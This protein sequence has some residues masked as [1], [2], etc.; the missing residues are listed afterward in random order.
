[1]KLGRS[2]RISKV[3]PHNPGKVERQQ[4]SAVTVGI[5]N[6]FVL[7]IRVI[8]SSILKLRGGKCR[9]SEEKFDRNILELPPTG[10]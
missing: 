5:L 10:G 6:V 1:M 2:N 7:S 3:L 4:G 8:T 9:K